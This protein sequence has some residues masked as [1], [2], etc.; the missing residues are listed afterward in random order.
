[1]LGTLLT[2]S[3]LCWLGSAAEGVA[4]PAAKLPAIP[5]PIIC[6]NPVQRG[7]E[8]CQFRNGV[9]DFSHGRQF[10]SRPRLAIPQMLHPFV[11]GRANIIQAFTE[12]RHLGNHLPNLAAV[13]GRAEQQV[14]FE[15][16]LDVVPTLE[17]LAVQD[18]HQLL[19]LQ[20]VGLRT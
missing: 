2:T 1:M 18:A 9:A 16:S 12:S 10:E 7:I 14:S 13:A 8:F 4:A 5:S 19:Q 20:Q 11:R 17:I 3:I 6:S 15:G